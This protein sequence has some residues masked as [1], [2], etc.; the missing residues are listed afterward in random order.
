MRGVDIEAVDAPGDRQPDDSEIMAQ[1]PLAAAFPAIHP[2]A[3]VVI[4]V[5]DEHGRLILQH[6][7]KRREEL[8]GDMKC[9]SRR[10]PPMRD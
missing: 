2:F 9:P 7:L 10:G 6:A 1:H 5:F 4:L 8:V 3:V